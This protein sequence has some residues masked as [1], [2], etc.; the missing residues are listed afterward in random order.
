MIIRMER[1]VKEYL[2]QYFKIILPMLIIGLVLTIVAIALGAEG[3]GDQ[4]SVPQTT[5]PVHMIVSADEDALAKIRYVS[6][7][8]EDLTDAS[9][10]D[11]VLYE[12]VGEQTRRKEET[13]DVSEVERLMMMYSNAE[14]YMEN[15]RYG[16]AAEIFEECAKKGFTD[17]AARVAECRE[18][19][20]Y[21]NEYLRAGELEE[22]LMYEEAAAIYDSFTGFRDCDERAA[23]CRNEIKYLEAFEAYSAGMPA[24]A[25]DI[26]DD[27]KDY[28]NSRANALVTR[29][30]YAVPGYDCIYF[31]RFE[32]DGDPGNGTERL[33]WELVCED[34]DTIT[35]VSRYLIHSRPYQWDEV[36]TTWESSNLREWL[37]GTFLRGAF[38]ATEKQVIVRT[39]CKAADNPEYNTY[40]GPDTEDYVWIFSAE[41]ALEYGIG[42]V[43]TTKYAMSDA[44][45]G[46]FYYLRTPGYK[47]SMVA[48]I[49]ADGSIDYIGASV[50]YY[51][52]IRPVIRIKA[53]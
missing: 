22:E 45:A 15:G 36:A 5:E 14:L 48:G 35:F 51:N 39:T 7:E 49:S 8:E 18:L 52:H 50:H 27:L 34:D 29:S 44:G 11:I 41:E 31:G 1:P 20:T 23:A 26:F 43:E 2:T 4:R 46:N 42:M 33:E 32:Q 28:K 40:G 13:S 3:Y 6:A 12:H 9:A 19:A 25:A 24:L 53:K 17:S 16:E 38:T 37:N 47:K 21:M 10:G 30:G